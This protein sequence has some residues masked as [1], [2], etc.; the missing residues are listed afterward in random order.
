MSNLFRE[1]EYVREYIDDLLVTTNGSHQDHL[2]KFDTV[3]TNLKKAGLEV[4]PEKYL[5][6]RHE[7]EYLGYLINRDGINAFKDHLEKLTQS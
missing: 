3:L 4:N 5:F 7:V 6:S 1:L 2:E